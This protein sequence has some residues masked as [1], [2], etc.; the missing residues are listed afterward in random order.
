MDPQ[1]VRQ[2]FSQLRDNELLRQA[3]LSPCDLLPAAQAALAEVLAVRFGPFSTLWEREMA[4]TGDL[5]ARLPDVRGFARLRGRGEPVLGGR[6]VPPYDGMLF[7]TTGGVGFLPT[8]ASPDT[9]FGDF[10]PGAFE[11]PIAE[12][13]GPRGIEWPQGAP[14]GGPRPLPLPLRARLDP[15]TAWIDRAHLEELSFTRRQWRFR[16]EGVADAV[17]RLAEDEDGAQIEAWAKRVALSL[18]V[19]LS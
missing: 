15:A 17:F 1:L 11:G 16:A 19:S 6:D 8:S 7:L 5:V 9:V 10:G 12:W 2:R 14:R 13:L 3:L 18:S 4:R